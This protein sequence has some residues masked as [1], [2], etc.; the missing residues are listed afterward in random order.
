MTPALAPAVVP[1]LASARTSIADYLSTAIWVYTILIFVYVLMQLL[2]SVGLRVPYSRVT[3]ALLTFL[4]DVCEP[5]LRIFRR[6]IPP[7]GAIDL[8]P[9]VA[10]VALQLINGFLVQGILHG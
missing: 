7:L 10:I 1:L 9:L 4:R 6:I 2:F 3:D 5:F 8:S